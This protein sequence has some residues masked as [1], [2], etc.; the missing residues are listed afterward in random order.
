MVDPK[1]PILTIVEGAGKSDEIRRLITRRAGL[2][3]EIDRI[4]DD[5]AELQETGREKVAKVIR[6]LPFGGTPKETETAARV[7]S[8]VL[9]LAKKPEQ[10]VIRAAKILSN[11][12]EAVRLINEIELVDV[13]K[14][15]ERLGGNEKLVK[16][17]L[18]ILSEKLMGAEPEPPLP[19]VASASGFRQAA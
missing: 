6:D 16:A 2:Q 15:R 12:P 11:R 5:I 7:G 4:N 10:D 13:K 18:D 9:Q 19:P 8:E 3:Q 1:K 14:I 17:F